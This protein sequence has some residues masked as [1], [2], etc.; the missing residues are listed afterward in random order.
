MKKKYLIFVVAAIIVLSVGFVYFIRNGSAK[1][2][3]ITLVDQNG[4][5][6]RIAADRTKLKLV[7]F[8]YTHCP[9]VCPTTTQKM[10]LLQKDLVKAGVFGKKIKYITITIDP[11]RDSAAVL[12]NYM[13]EFHLKNDGNWIFLSG[14]REDLKSSQKYIR[15]AADALKFQYKDEGNGYYSHTAF[16]YLLDENNRFI[17]TFPMGKDF[18]KKEVYSQIMQRLK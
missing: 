14:N 12:K 7:E 17:N 6:Y 8:V 2:P 10:S 4:I 13:K 15:E 5:N 18:N 9:S 1:L 3:N 11:Y 16:V